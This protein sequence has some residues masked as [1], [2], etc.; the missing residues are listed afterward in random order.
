MKRYDDPV[1]PW[2]RWFRMQV[3]TV[4]NTYLDIRR[5]MKW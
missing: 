3:L 5:S 4:V 1:S 2:R